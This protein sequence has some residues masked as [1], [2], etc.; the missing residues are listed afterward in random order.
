MTTSTIDDS[1]AA[2]TTASVV[3]LRGAIE[4]IPDPATGELEAIA[5]ALAPKFPELAYADV[6]EVVRSTYRELVGKARIHAHLIPL[7]VN[8]SRSRLTNKRSALPTSY[9]SGR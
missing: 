8:L 2:T 5:R 3:P 6:L 9:P 4:S 7:T 1:P